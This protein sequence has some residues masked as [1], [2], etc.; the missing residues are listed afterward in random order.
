MNVKLVLGS[1]M[2]EV[3]IPLAGDFIVDLV[4]QRTSPFLRLGG[5][6]ALGR[7]FASGDH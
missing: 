7:W 1:A 4:L 5:A 3:N 6:E 2:R